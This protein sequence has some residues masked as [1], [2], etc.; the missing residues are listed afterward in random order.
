MSQSSSDYPEFPEVE[1]QL[2]YNP[3]RFLDQV[4]KTGKTKELTAK[5]LI[6]G[7]ESVEH[8]RMWINVE[9]DLHDGPRKQVARWIGSRQVELKHPD[10]IEESEIEDRENVEEIEETSEEPTEES[11]SEPTEVEA[12]ENLR[13]PTC[14][15]DLTEEILAGQR[16]YWCHE[17]RDFQEPASDPPAPTTVTAATAAVATDGGRHDPDATLRCP[18]CHG[19]LPERSVGD[20]QDARWCDWC[21]TV[22]TGVISV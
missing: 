18:D 6:R 10:G 13:C 7:L 14:G 2:G 22:V 9:A 11:E 12:I 17:C 19:K 5:G 20:D 8:C 16:G 3:A 1:E 4:G 15:H 21:K